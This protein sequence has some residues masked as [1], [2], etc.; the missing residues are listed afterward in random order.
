MCIWFGWMERKTLALKC[1]EVLKA[2]GK[3]PPGSIQS[4][5]KTI[6]DA[7]TATYGSV[8]VLHEAWCLAN[9]LSPILTS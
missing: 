3:Y 2:S 7:N 6:N 1:D 4:P 5:P 8:R 9:G